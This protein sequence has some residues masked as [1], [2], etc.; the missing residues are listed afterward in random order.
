MYFTVY[1]KKLFVF[2]DNLVEP[3]ARTTPKIKRPVKRD[4]RMVYEKCY[5]TLNQIGFS[6]VPFVDLLFKTVIRLMFNAR[7]L[8][9]I[10]SQ[11]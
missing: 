6:S 4:I 11:H 8:K 3:S 5:R 10:N 2:F 1:S 7:F 9:K